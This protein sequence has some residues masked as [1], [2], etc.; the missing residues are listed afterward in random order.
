[1]QILAERNP[2]PL[3][4]HD[5][6]SLLFSETLLRLPGR[7]HRLVCQG[8]LPLGILVFVGTS[9]G[10]LLSRHATCCIRIRRSISTSPSSET[11]VW[12]CLMT[13]TATCMRCTSSPTP[14]STGIRICHRK[15]LLFLLLLD[16][17]CILSV[18]LLPDPVLQACVQ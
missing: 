12:W 17:V 1:M 16:V 15:R 9:E 4:R 10:R 3:C 11:I 13:T 7:M 2:R 14:S 8:C 6:R 18:L 5:G